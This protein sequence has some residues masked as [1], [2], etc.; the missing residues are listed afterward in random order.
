ML[1]TAGSKLPTPGNNKP[2]YSFDLFKLVMIST[3]APFFFPVSFFQAE[4][5]S[6]S[7]IKYCN[8]QYYI[9][10]LV[11]GTPFCFLSGDDAN[12]NATANDFIAASTL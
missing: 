7:V 5:I 10:P 3:S 8:F 11:L 9:A 2:E 12:L 1:L 6:C 4:N